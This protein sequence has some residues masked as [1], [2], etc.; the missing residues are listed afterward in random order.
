M[1][2]IVKKGDFDETKGWGGAVGKFYGS[3]TIQGKDSLVAVVWI[4]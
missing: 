3:M 4:L 1:V 2:S